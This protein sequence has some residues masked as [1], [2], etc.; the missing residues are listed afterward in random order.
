MKYASSSQSCRRFVLGLR[1]M[2]LI[3]RYMIFWQ[4]DNTV[5]FLLKRPCYKTVTL[6]N[7]VTFSFPKGDRFSLKRELCI[8]NNSTSREYQL[9]TSS[10]YKIILS[11]LVFLQIQKCIK[12]GSTMT[13]A[14]SMTFYFTWLGGF[15]AVSLGMGVTVHSTDSCLWAAL[16][17]LCLLCLCPCASTYR[18]WAKFFHDVDDPSLMNIE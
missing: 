7:M 12:S 6:C 13:S 15:V 5:F 11:F 17:W 16:S 18:M 14:I 10:T 3:F 9:I 2:L 4:F 8:F 1:E